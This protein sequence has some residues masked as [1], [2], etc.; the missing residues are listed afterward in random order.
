VPASLRPAHGQHTV[1]KRILKEFTNPQ[2]QLA[3]YEREHGRRQ[4]RTP[5]AGVFMTQ[6]DRY[7]SRGAEE[8]WNLFEKNFPAMLRAVRARTALDDP[9]IVS[10]IKDLLAVHWTRSRGIMAAR[11]VMTERLVDESKQRMLTTR[12]DL[13]AQGLREETGLLPAS[14]SALE[15]INDR[16]HSRVV[17]DN[18]AKWH[19]DRDPINFAAARSH[20]ERFQVQVGFST[21]RDFII[22]DSPVI[23][24]RQ[25]RPGAGPHQ[26]VAIQEADHVAMPMAPHIVVGLGPDAMII[27]VPDDVVALYNTWQWRA[28]DTWIAAKPAGTGDVTLRSADALTKIARAQH[29]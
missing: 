22:S 2:G 28:Y 3:V 1:T 21:G 13:L 24:T 6:F 5:G 17:R 11:A 20:F 7:D 26:G 16:A 9:A 8:R 12:P 14:G 23:T 27:D 4:I 19:S 29:R 25:D 18:E 10:T 15:W